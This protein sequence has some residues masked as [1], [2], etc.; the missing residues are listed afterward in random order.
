MYDMMYDGATTL[1]NLST[2]FLR[3]TVA[4]YFSKDVVKKTTNN[5]NKS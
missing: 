1:I 2:T 4:V 3:D 5:I